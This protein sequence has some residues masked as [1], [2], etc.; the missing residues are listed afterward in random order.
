MYILFDIGGTNMRIAA[1]NSNGLIKTAVIPT[2]QNFQKGMTAFTSTA[3]N[4][5]AGKK[6]KAVAGGIAGVL[7]STKTTIIKSPNLHWVK[8]PVRDT[9]QKQLS[10]PVFMENDADIAALGEAYFGAGKG[11]KIVAYL[12]ISTGVGGGLVIDKKIAP[13]NWGFE[14]GHQI[15]SHDG[16]TLESLIS[17]N[18]LLKKYGQPAFTIKN[19]RL[20]RETAQWLAYGLNNTIVYWSPDIVILGGS[21]VLRKVGISLSETK[22]ILAKH[23]TIIPQLPPIVKSKLKGEAGLYGGLALLKTIKNRS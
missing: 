16:C 12:T 8:K 4:L 11:Y 6:I 21:M 14:P 5:A 19:K 13:K 17:G 20:W 2:S 9:L 23:K 1:A 7:N 15:L 3:F 10:A 22:K 18:A